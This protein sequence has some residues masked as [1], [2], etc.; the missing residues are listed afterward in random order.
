MKKGIVFFMLISMAGCAPTNIKP[1]DERAM[2]DADLVIESKQLE[3]K[4][5]IPQNPNPA[6]AGVIPAIIGGM[7]D[8]A[9]SDRIVQP[10]QNTFINRKVNEVLVNDVQARVKGTHQVTIKSFAIYTD[11]D[12]KRSEMIQHRQN[13]L[14]LVEIKHCFNLGLNLLQVDASVKFYRSAQTYPFYQA[15]TTTQSEIFGEFFELNP[16]VSEDKEPEVL[17]RE[18]AAINKRFDSQIAENPGQ[19]DVLE[20]QRQKE[21]KISR[22]QK[23]NSIYRKSPAEKLVADDVN[24]NKVIEDMKVRTQ[25]VVQA[26]LEDAFTSNEADREFASMPGRNLFS[27]DGYLLKSHSGQSSSVFRQRRSSLD[28]AVNALPAPIYSFPV[29]NKGIDFITSCR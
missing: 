26:A 16:I 21:L 12:A 24:F 29:G 9:I 23:A 22:T 2:M 19:R 6:A 20:K 8:Q 17:S 25:E 3:P 10:L 28:Q 7:R 13:P 18:A 11:P 4:V 14:I 5:A 15:Q 1:A 27:V